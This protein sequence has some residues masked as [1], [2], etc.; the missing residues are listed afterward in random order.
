MKLRIIDYVGDRATDTEQ[1]NK[2][3]SLIIEGLKEK[4]IVELDFSNMKTILP[5]FLNNAIGALYKN[6]TSEYLNQYLKLKNLCKDDLS[7][8]KR[9]IKNSKEFYENQ[10]ILYYWYMYIGNVK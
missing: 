7:L 3:Y 9:V 1:G 5:T 10:E 8:L 4:E 2:I 6:Y